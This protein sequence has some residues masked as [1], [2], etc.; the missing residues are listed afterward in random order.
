MWWQSYIVR[1]NTDYRLRKTNA[2]EPNTAMFPKLPLSGT[3]RL[4]LLQTWTTQSVGTTAGKASSYNVDDWNGNSENMWQK[5]GE[6]ASK[7]HTNKEIHKPQNASAR[8]KQSFYKITRTN[9]KMTGVGPD[10]L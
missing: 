9:Q 3:V 5:T 8:E 4:N 10:L 7:H 2:Q 6:E 1:T